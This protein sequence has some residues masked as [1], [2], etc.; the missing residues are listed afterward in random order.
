ML[1]GRAL[2][3]GDERTVRD[4]DRREL[5]HGAELK[6]EAGSARV[7]L[8]GRVDQENVGQLRQRGNLRVSRWGKRLDPRGS[9]EYAAHTGMATAFRPQ[10]TQSVLALAAH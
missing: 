9:Y 5:E 3:L 10:Q 2:A 7:V 6:R 1:V 8:A 4:A